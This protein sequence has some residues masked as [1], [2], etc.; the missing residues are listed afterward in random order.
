MYIDSQRYHPIEK[1]RQTAL[2]FLDLEPISVE[3]HHIRR[4]ILFVISVEVLL[5]P[6][7]HFLGIVIVKNALIQVRT[8]STFITLHI[9]CI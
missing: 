5:Q 7:E 4:S 1:F 6:L 3:R 2:Q 9:M 8:V